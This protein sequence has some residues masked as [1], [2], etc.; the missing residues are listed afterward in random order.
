MFGMCCVTSARKSSGSYSS[1]GGSY[2]SAGGIG[3]SND[4]KTKP[5]K[6]IFTMLFGSY[7]GDWDSHNN[8]LRAPL[9]SQPSALTSLWG[10]SVEW[11][12]HHMALGETIGYGVRLTIS[13]DSTLYPCPSYNRGI[14]SALMGDPTLRMH[15][16]APPSGVCCS[17]AGERIARIEWQASPDTVVGYHV[18]RAPSV[19]EQFVRVNA[20]PVT[21][22]SYADTDPHATRNVY[23]VRAVK[24]ETGSG[25]YFNLSQGVFDS[26]NMATA[27]VRARGVEHTRAWCTVRTGSGRSISVSLLPLDMSPVTVLVTDVA[28]RTA[29]RY[30]TASA[31]RDIR[32]NVPLHSLAHGVYMLRIEHAGNVLCRRLSTACSA[33]PRR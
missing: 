9:I 15:I 18:Y 20:E 3:T 26:L 1:G 27:G 24:L 4:F 22:T 10:S 8:F 6:T 23:M 13:G 14:Y 28:G 29:F 32:V 31:R 19:D 2:T 16:V 30:E 21:D 17:K 25:T 11:F 33:T 5:V 12:F 7:F